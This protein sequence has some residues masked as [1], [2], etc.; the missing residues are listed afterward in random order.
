MYQRGTFRWT[1]SSAGIPTLRDFKAAKKH[2][3]NVKPL[4]GSNPEL[5]PLGYNRR[6][7]QCEIFG[8]P[9]NNRIECRLWGQPCVVYTPDN[10]ILITHSGWV[11]PTTAAFIDQLIPSEY[12]TVYIDKGKMVFVDAHPEQRSAPR[13]TT[14]KY[15]INSASP[16]ILDINPLSN[17][18]E[19][20]EGELL[21]NWHINKKEWNTIKK[22]EFKKL[23]PFLQYLRVLNTMREVNFDTEPQ[24]IALKM[25]GLQSGEEGEKQ[26]QD[27]LEKHV[28]G[29]RHTYGDSDYWLRQLFRRTNSVRLFDFQRMYGGAHQG[30]GVFERFKFA[31][32]RLHGNDSAQLGCNAFHLYDLMTSKKPE[33]WVVA[34]TIMLTSGSRLP[35]WYQP[36]FSNVQGYYADQDERMF[37]Q[38]IDEVIHDV[39]RIKYADQLFRMVEW[40]EGRIPLARNNNFMY[41]NAHREYMKVLK[42]NKSTKK[43]KCS[44]VV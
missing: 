6:Y 3:I 40:S 25:L 20:I 35:R 28:S 1:L 43:S 31:K 27:L 12:G 39:L 18:L 10:K 4:R 42:G 41:V 29:Y 36:Q 37:E 7:K 32:G 5:R 33:D 11:S 24:Q 15:I 9:L 22:H 14:D 8:N 21:C 30:L 13:Q 2:Y 19:A 38:L 16:L 26:V 17:K 23:Q 34:H 44:V